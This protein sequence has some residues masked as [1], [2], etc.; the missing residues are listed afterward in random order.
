MDGHAFPGLWPN[1]D[2]IKLL[3]KSLQ[4]ATH[5]TIQLLYKSLQIATHKYVGMLWSLSENNFNYEKSVK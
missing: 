1:N 5:D 2:T 4:I 3:Y